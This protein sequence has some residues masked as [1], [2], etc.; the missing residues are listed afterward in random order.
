MKESA[1]QQPS[2]GLAPRNRAVAL[3]VALAIQAAV[4]PMAYAQ[5]APAARDKPADE[6]LEQIVVTGSRI[7]RRDYQANS[8]NQT[9]DSTSL[10][11][12]AG[13]LSGALAFDVIHSD[14]LWRHILEFV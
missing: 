3:A 8:P 7:V 6:A 1:L 12:Q 9:I 14:D 2:V 5:Q 13:V 10:E 11:D 4:I